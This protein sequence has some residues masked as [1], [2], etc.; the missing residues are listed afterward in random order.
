MLKNLI[1]KTT[2]L[3]KPIFPALFFT[4][5][6]LAFPTIN[7]S[8]DAMGYSTASEI[9]SHH[10][11]YDQLIVFVNYTLNYSG[12]KTLMVMKIIN[13]CMAGLC[14]LILGKTL[15]S[16]GQASIWVFLAGSVYGF[17]R[18]ATENEVY[19]F[20][21]FFGLLAGMWFIKFEFS[22][23]FTHLIFGFAFLSIAVLFHQ[24]YVFWYFAAGLVFFVTYFRRVKIWLIPVFF[25]IVIVMVHFFAAA[26]HQ[27]SF[28]VWIF[29]DVTKGLV[30]LS[31]GLNNFIIT[32]INFM[33]TFFQIHGN[34]PL[35][36]NKFSWIYTFVFISVVSMVAFFYFIIKFRPVIRNEAPTNKTIILISW[37]A[38][39]F[40]FLFAWFSVGNAEFMV[41]LPFL[42]ITAIALS[43]KINEKPM[44]ALSISLL[45]WNLT[46]GIVPSALLNY[47][48]NPQILKFIEKQNNLIFISE[49]RVVFENYVLHLRDQS[50]CIREPENLINS[51]IILSK[52]PATHENVQELTLL[53]DSAFRINIPVY[54]DCI[55]F[56]RVMNRETLLK[57]NKNDLFFNQ[58]KT[59]IIDSFS[60]FYGNIYIHRLDKS[61]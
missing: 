59:S 56:P 25:A 22:K 15:K 7:S 18:Y 20:P 4:V 54:T 29:K 61:N 58:F 51:H 17:M 12:V 34:I 26:V 41:M 45:V 10:L 57:G 14:L 9:N 49:N 37:I 38:F 32:P 39:L 42:M 5:I 2:L 1:S 31:P 6:Y 21:L 23:K 60:T 43:Y 16:T 27:T 19:I 11:L 50:A 53:I 30:D 52:S 13:A 46:L 8:G 44:I 55:R 3:N 40:Q 36:L 33:R 35:I 24:S 48:A 28:Y 47:S